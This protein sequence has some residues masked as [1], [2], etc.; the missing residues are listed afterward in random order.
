[1]STKSPP[2]PVNCLCEKI[3]AEIPLEFIGESPA[4]KEL[5]GVLIKS[6]DE[7][8]VSCLPGDLPKEF[9][10]DISKLKTFEDHIKIS[11]LDISEKV[12]VLIEPGTI[13]ASVAPP[14]SEEELTRLDEKVE[15]DVS[16]V[17]GIAEKVPE[18]IAGVPESP[19]KE[20]AEVKKK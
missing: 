20:K 5:A 4:V 12:K 3:E 2:A 15:E 19:E 16:K 18:E 1:M 10:A 9:I 14:R 7:I 6:M 17:E 11:D 8:P 13:I